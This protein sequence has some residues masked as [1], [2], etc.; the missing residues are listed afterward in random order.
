M[1]SKN[2]AKRRPKL[3]R[4]T[5]LQNVAQKQCKMQCKYDAKCPKMMQNVVKINENSEP[6]TM[7]NAVNNE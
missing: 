5:P 3:M 7:Q 2:N 6:K 1:L 4:T